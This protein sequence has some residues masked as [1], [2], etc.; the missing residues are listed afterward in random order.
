MTTTAF[1]NRDTQN[2]WVVKGDEDTVFLP[3]ATTM[4]QALVRIGEAGLIRTGDWLPDYG[5]VYS[6]TLA[7]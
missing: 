5:R 1:Y 4:R 2:I 7:D 3:K 6:V